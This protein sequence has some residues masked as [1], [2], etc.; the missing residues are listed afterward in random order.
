MIRVLLVDDQQL[1]RTAVRAIIDNDPGIEVVGE[2][3]DGREA[4]R[5]TRQLLPDLVL[6]DLRMPVLDGIE[7]TTAICADDSLQSV[8]VLVLTTFEDDESVGAA[9]RAG[10]SGFVG[11]GVD[12][13]QLLHAVRT[14]AAGDSLLSPVATASIIKRYLAQA[15]EP[16][17]ELGEQLAALTEREREIVVLV[18]RGRSNDEIAS[19]LVIS[20]A[21][22]KTHVNRAMSK[23]GAHDRAQLVVLAY[24]GGLLRPGAGPLA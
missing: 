21:T 23:L 18:A 7:A 16:A 24:E 17:A 4:V 9:L 22:A 15:P 19:E 5:L 12:A 8:R 11:K 6:M 13:P 2:A 14:V 10:A 1:I 3:G 20:P